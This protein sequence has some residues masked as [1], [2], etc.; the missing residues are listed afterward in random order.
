M[1][2][3]WLGR[4]AVLGLVALAGCEPVGPIAGG[5]LGGTGAPVPMDWEA[6]RSVETFQL[7]TRPLDPYS[8]NLWGVVVD[9]HLYVAS[10][11][12]GESRWV[13]YLT[14]DP[15]VRLRMADKLYDLRASRVLDADELEVV[16]LRYIDKYKIEEDPDMEGE[17]GEEAWVFR[18][19]PR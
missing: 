17:F 12:G 7:E 16:R 13:G 8:V 14:E 1:I 5:E 3:R 19:D 18:L 11:N 2:A 10:G 4:T 15:N 9:G 6:A